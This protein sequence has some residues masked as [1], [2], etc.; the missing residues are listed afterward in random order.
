MVAGLKAEVRDLAAG[1]EDAH[2]ILATGWESA[3]PVLA[4]PAK[5]ARLYFVQDFEPSFYPAGQRGAA[6][7]GHLPA[8]GSTA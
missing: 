2:A 1:I 5:G 4:S 3:Y 7:R 8:S 6:R